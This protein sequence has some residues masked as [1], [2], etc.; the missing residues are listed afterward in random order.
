MKT[1]TRRP[2]L[3]THRK[4]DFC[5]SPGRRFRLDVSAG[6]ALSPGGAGSR[7]HCGH[8]LPYGRDRRGRQRLFCFAE[9]AEQLAVQRLSAQFRRFTRG[10][11]GA[12]RPPGRRPDFRIA[13]AK[14]IREQGRVACAR[15]RGRR[16]TDNSIPTAPRFMCRM[17]SSPTWRRGTRTCCSARPST[18]IARTRWSG[19]NGPRR[20]ARCW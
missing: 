13:R 19:W 12:R 3:A 1:L 16:R 5:R 8:A 2:P 4:I 10:N 17:N 6:T 14:Q 11:C 18:R 7:Q 15:R 20:T 9:I